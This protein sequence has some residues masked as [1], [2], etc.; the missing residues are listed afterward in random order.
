[1]IIENEMRNTLMKIMKSV[2]GSI[3][4][5]RASIQRRKT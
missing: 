3:K 2:R 5:S 4:D 1:M